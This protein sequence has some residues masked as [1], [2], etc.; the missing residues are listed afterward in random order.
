LFMSSLL[1]FDF[2]IN[3]IDLL[4]LSIQILLLLG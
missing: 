2:G 3:I 4:I 1:L